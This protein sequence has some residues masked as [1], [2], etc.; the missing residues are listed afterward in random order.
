PSQGVT[1]DQFRA[2]YRR[3][4]VA[5]WQAEWA[6]RQVQDDFLDRELFRALGQA[7]S[8]GLTIA[9]LKNAEKRVMRLDLDGDELVTLPEIAPNRGY[10]GFNIVPLQ[11]TSEAPFWLYE[12][13]DKGRRLLAERL[14]KHYDR[15]S[16]GKLGPNEFACDAT[17][18][19]RLD[20][21]HDGF[22]Q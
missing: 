17:Q 21:N 5:P 12:S 9:D 7:N 10:P 2:Y 4:G 22:L 3:G 16:D 20:T 18:F 8:D 15:N 19:G 6:S 11:P 13:S 1:L 14:L